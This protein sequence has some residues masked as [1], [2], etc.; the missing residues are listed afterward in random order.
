MR[1]YSDHKLEHY[2]RLILRLVALGRAKDKALQDI[3]RTY[4]V[5]A[6]DRQKLMEMLD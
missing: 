2:Y 3:C 5:T 6:A 4:I 1:Y